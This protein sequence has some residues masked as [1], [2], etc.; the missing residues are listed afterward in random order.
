MQIG[1]SDRIAIFGGGGFIGSHLVKG[2]LADRYKNVVCVDLVADK[3]D[4]I[5]PGGGASSCSAIFAPMISLF[6]ELSRRATW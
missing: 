6:A 3:L 1:R 5:V 4:R 2:L